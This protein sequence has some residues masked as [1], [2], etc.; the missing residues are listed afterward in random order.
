MAAAIERGRQAALERAA[1]FAHLSVDEE[2]WQRY[3]A[4]QRKRARPP[5]RIESIEVR[6]ESGLSPSVIQS[7]L[8]VRT[9]E[10]FDIAALEKDIQQ[11]YGMDIFENVRFRLEPE[12]TGARLEIDAREKSWGTNHIRFKLEFQEDFD[13]HH[14]YNL[15]FQVTAMPLNAYGAEWRN[16][17][18]FGQY[19]RFF[20]EFYQPITASSQWFISPNITYDRPEVSVFARHR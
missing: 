5:P 16:E 19:F 3:L 13:T 9:A 18:Q 15:G 8:R 20:S 17:L 14:D 10:P 6:N 2:E 12:G 11:I 4:R 7:R 1:D